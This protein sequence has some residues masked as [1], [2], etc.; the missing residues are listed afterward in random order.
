MPTEFSLQSHLAFVREQSPFYAD[1]WADQPANAPLQALPITR[2]EDYWQAN[3]L[4]DNQVLTDRHHQGVVYKSGGTSGDP[5]FSFFSNEDWYQFCAVF[6][7]GMAQHLLADGQRHVGNLFYGG[8]MYAS[9]NFI[10]RALEEAGNAVSYP[11]AGHAPADEVVQTIEQFGINTL[12][13]V[14]TTFMKLLPALA[15]AHREQPLPITRFMYGGE[16]LFP[17]Q[18]AAIKRA[19]PDCTPSSIGIA[20]V[21]YGEMG[22][23][24]ADCELG[25][26][27]VFDQSICLEILDEH[28]GVIEQPN[29]PGELHIT[30]FRRKLMP[31]VRYPVGD[32]GM[33]T[34]PT[35][36]P[37]RKFK[38]LGRTDAGARI[39]VVSLYVEDITRIVGQQA[40]DVGVIHSQLLIEHFDQRDKGTLKIA[41]SNPQ[42]VPTDAAEQIRQALFKERPML[43]SSIEKG[44]IHP[45]EIQFCRG[46]ELHTNPR[47]GKLIR[48][49]DNRL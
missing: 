29:T 5:K 47:T 13:G 27:R 25:E 7:N 32:R 37:N 35:G 19:L 30:N 33:W 42:A 26:H 11:I 40:G 1:Y 8:Q 34:E 46:D 21:D 15:A 49:V 48:V 9:F 20:G 6:G 36:T 16:P 17:D 3:G 10:T 43:P 45:F 22:W 12:V 4:H 2:H 18:V 31:I 14:P 23:I 38:V 24:S 41:V 39:G 28:G 44:V